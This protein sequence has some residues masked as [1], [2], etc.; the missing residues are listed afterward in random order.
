MEFGSGGG[1]GG[2]G[3]GDHDSSDAHRRKKR[4][5][6]HTANQIQRLEGY[7]IFYLSTSSSMCLNLQAL[8]M[9]TEFYLFSEVPLVYVIG[10]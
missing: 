7:I 4:Y 1:G 8:S 2:S 5:H 6:R 9:E 3:G 10:N